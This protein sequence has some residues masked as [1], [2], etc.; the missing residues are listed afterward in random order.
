MTTKK[1][2]TSKGKK[3]PAA[4]AKKAGGASKPK[5][6]K[7]SRVFAIRLTTKELEAIHKA[8]G[9]R[10]ASRFM[11]AVGRAFAAGDESAFRAVV[12]EAREARA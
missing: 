11:R 8:A 10:N 12:K 4:R 6:E 1:T 2:A 3:A 9:P 7:P 5:A